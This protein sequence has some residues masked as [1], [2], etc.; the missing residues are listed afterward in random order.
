[1]REVIPS[2]TH[3]HAPGEERNIRENSA[4]AH[5]QCSPGGQIQIVGVAEIGHEVPPFPF[6]HAAFKGRVQMRLPVNRPC[7]KDQVQSV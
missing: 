6:R 4:H 1:M 2:R 3:G 5:C 7:A